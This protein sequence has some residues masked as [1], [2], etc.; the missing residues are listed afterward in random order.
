[1]L[2]RLL[3]MN[4]DAEGWVLTVKVHVYVICNLD[5][6]TRNIKLE[7]GGSMAKL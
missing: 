6:P 7:G 3:E 1:M 4:R 2:S 5:T